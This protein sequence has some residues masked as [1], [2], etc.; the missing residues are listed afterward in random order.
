MSFKGFVAPLLVMAL[1]ALP[2]C[3]Q[4]D[5]ANVQRVADQNN[6]PVYRVNVVARTAQAVDYRHK[7]DTV[8]LDLVGTSLMPKAHGEAKVKSHRDRTS[9]ETKLTDMKPASTFGPEY[10]TYVLW[11]ITPEGRPV[12]LGEAQVHLR[13]DNNS[14]LTTT[15]PLQAFGLIVTAEPYA[16][17]TRPSDVVVLENQVRPDTKANVQPIDAHY[18]ALN[19]GEYRVDLDPSQLPSQTA[20]KNTP[21]ELLEAENAVAI[22]RA[23]GADKYAADSLQKAQDF[24]TNAQNAYRN[25][26]DSKNIVTAAKSAEQTAE[27]ARLITIRKKADEQ[28]AREREQQQ[29][30]ITAAQQQ[31]QQQQQA[32]EQAQQTAEQAR[33]QAQQTEQQRQQAEAERQA[34]LQAKQQA[35]AAA[36]QAALERQQAEAARQQALAQQQQLAQQAQQAQM[37]AQQAEQGRL[38]AERQVQETRDRLTQQLNQVLQTRQTARGLIVNMNDVLFDTG[39]ATL[40]PGAR[41]RLARVAGIILAYPDLKLEI[42]GYTDSTGTPE[43]NRD[44]S[45]RRADTV[46]SF[47]ATQGVHDNNIITHGFGEEDPVASNNTASGRQL[48]RRVELVVSGNAIGVQGQSGMVGSTSSSTTSSTLGSTSTNSTTGAAPNTGTMPSSNTAAQPAASG[49]TAVTPQ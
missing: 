22:A 9:V 13:H 27:D 3:A 17:V 14:E 26:E 42:D 23:T 1:S 4:D 18:E 6:T 44:L 29:E 36:Q 33:L 32:A 12:N 46:R 30:R 5:A 28:Q 41:E 16:N 19:R 47:L 45:Q 8:T 24:L 10:L 48:N 34:A 43:F 15:T 35:D 38:Q 37:Q 11:A 31:A 49:N 20:D 39:K 2:L 21:L 25:K 40:K 7:G